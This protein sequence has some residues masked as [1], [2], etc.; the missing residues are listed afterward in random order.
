[1]RFSA[2]FFAAGLLL[3]GLALSGC[4]NQS[5]TTSAAAAPST[6]TQSSP[7]APAGRLKADGWVST[8]V[9]DDQIEGATRTMMSNAL[10]ACM[11]A[12]SGELMACLD[13]ETADAIDPSGSAKKACAGIS[14]SKGH[15]Q[16]VFGGTL[17]MKLRAKNDVP[18]SQEAW[19]DSERA[20][21][22]ELMAAALA[23]SFSCMKSVGTAQ[24]AY[25]A[26][27]AQNLLARFGAPTDSAAPCMDLQ[28]DEKFGQC[29]GEAGI[30]SLLEAAAGRP[31]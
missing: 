4:Q 2:R 21:R 1:M 12:S 22:E 20:M 16:C 31:I 29:V 18:M 15:Y 3:A 9:F 11:K 14:E 5:G 7:A 24:S 26:C 25:R 17:V 13:E 8:G 28:P 30:V 27:L 23:D 19:E 6:K 10:N